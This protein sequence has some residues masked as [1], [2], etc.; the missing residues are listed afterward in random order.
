MIMYWKSELLG[1]KAPHVGRLHSS[2]MFD[3]KIP[4]NKMNSQN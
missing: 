4:L 2:Q 1:K 3:K